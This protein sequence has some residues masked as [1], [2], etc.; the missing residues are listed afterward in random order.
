MLIST[1]A[2]YVFYEQVKWFKD[3]HHQWIMNHIVEAPQCQP[4]TLV[5]HK[6]VK[7]VFQLFDSQGN[8]RRVQHTGKFMSLYFIAKLQ[9]H[10]LWKKK[11]Q[12]VENS[13]LPNMQ[14]SH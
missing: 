9:M 11:F 12:M 10:Q 6:F 14:N 7:H 1:Q 13:K 5:L 3:S 8:S 4:V 2:K